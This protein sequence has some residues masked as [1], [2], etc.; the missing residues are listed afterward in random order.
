M[1]TRLLITVIL[2]GILGCTEPW[3]SAWAAGDEL[4]ELR[5]WL[6]MPREHRPD[7]SSESWATEGL[8]RDGAET[9]RDLLWKDYCEGQMASMDSLLESKQVVD[10]KLTMRFDL[11]TFGEKPQGGHS[12]YLSLHGGGGAPAGVNDSQWRN[13]QQLY[14]PTEGIYISPRA[15]T[16]TW[17]LWHQSHVDGMF[18]QIIRALVMT[19]QVNADRVYVM[20]YS[21]GGDGVYQLGPRMA[22][23]WAAAAMM[24]GHPNDASAL[25]LR[26]IGFAIHMGALDSAYDRNDVAKKWGEELDRLQAA[27]PQGYAHTT[28][29]HEG[30]GHWMDRQD[31]VA[32]DYLATFT[33]NAAPRHVVW[34]QDDVLRDRFYW[35]AI[36]TEAQK[37]GQQVIAIIDGQT[38]RI[39]TQDVSSL[40]VRLDDRLVNLDEPVSVV[41]ND[42]EPMLGSPARDVRTLHQTMID[43]GDRQLMWSA[44]IDWANPVKPNE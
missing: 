32:L 17:D 19:G 26:N 39:K 28:T 10:G 34:H 20:G 1:T 15:P 7:L 41:I 2:F 35:L 38:L 24:A 29:L 31:A 33:R 40:T 6:A 16:D 11:R 8:G 43:S 14:T 5:G 25:N 44:T 42:Q 3:T 13:Q 23:S 27:D 18:R 22:D 4:D 12:L 36:P 30:K 21:A 37:I 9:A